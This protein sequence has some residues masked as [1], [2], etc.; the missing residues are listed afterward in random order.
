MKGSNFGAAL[1]SGAAPLPTDH[2]SQVSSTLWHYFL[3]PGALNSSFLSSKSFSI[4]YTYEEEFEVS[5]PYRAKP[6]ARWFLHAVL[7]G[8]LG[9]ARDWPRGT[10]SLLQVGGSL[11]TGTARNRWKSEPCPKSP[12][13]EGGPP[14]PFPAPRTG[15]APA[16]PRRALRVVPAAPRCAAAAA[17]GNICR[18][19]TA[20]GGEGGWGGTPRGGPAPLPCPDRRVASGRRGAAGR[21][22]EGRSARA[23][24]AEAMAGKGDPLAGRGGAEAP[25]WGLRRRGARDER[26]RARR[27]WGGRER[28]ALEGKGSTDSLGWQAWC[29]RGASPAGKTKT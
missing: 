28:G 29:L 26:G 8:S 16:G 3:A 9:P 2:P 23:P 14:G 25:V 1:L 27:P 10:R 19:N 21:R 12:K 5:D 7:G 24:T 6:Q 13:P 20:A 4:P 17:G 22:G 18:G 11:L 15:R